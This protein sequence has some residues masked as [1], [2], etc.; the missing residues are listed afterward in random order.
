MIF[1]LTSTHPPTNT[2]ICIFQTHKHI[3]KAQL[4]LLQENIKFTGLKSHKLP[5]PI[6]ITKLQP[7]KWIA[8][9]FQEFIHICI[10]ANHHSHTVCTFLKSIPLTT[11]NSESTFCLK[12]FL[13]FLGSALLSTL[14]SSFFVWLLS[15]AIK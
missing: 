6:Q 7:E 14:A 4:E 1:L 15:V 13:D 2:Q 10:E 11:P 3:Y 8:T 9:K 5:S 12:C